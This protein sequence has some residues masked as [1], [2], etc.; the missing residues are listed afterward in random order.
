M[1]TLYLF[2]YTDFGYIT[3]ADTRFLTDYYD[4]SLDKDQ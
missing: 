2:Y 1:L 3:S 4:R